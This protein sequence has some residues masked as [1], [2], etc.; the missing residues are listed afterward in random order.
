MHPLGFLTHRARLGVL[1]AKNLNDSP[2]KEDIKGVVVIVDISGYTKLTDSLARMGSSERLREI[3]NPPFELIIQTIHAHN[4]SIIKFAGDSVLAIWNPAVEKLNMKDEEREEGKRH[5]RHEEV[6][7]EI[8]GKVVQCCCNLMCLF[9]EYKLQI[10]DRWAGPN[11]Q[12]RVSTVAPPEADYSTVSS[13]KGGG[14]KQTKADRRNSGFVDSFLI[15]MNDSGVGRKNSVRRNQHDATSPG[16]NPLGIDS[17]RIHIGVGIGHFRHVFLGKS[18]PKAQSPI[19]QLEGEEGEGDGQVKP[20]AAPEED[21]LR[22]EQFVSGPAVQE[23][24]DMLVYGKTGELALP[25]RILSHFRR[26]IGREPRLNLLIQGG[27]E[28]PILPNCCIVRDKFEDIVEILSNL[29]REFWSSSITSD[30][31]SAWLTREGILPSL[32]KNM[33]A[34]MKSLIFM[35][36]SLQQFF[37]SKLKE[38]QKQIQEQKELLTGGDLMSNNGSLSRKP[39]KRRSERR[40]SVTEDAR[41][42]ALALINLD[43]YNQVRR[44][45]I[46]F[47]Q[48]QGLSLDT[49]GAD[50]NLPDLQNFMDA[51]LVGVNTHGGCCRQLNCDEKGLCALLVWGLEGFAHEKGEEKHAV[52]AAL[53][54][55]QSLLAIFGSS[56]SIGVTAGQVFAGVIGDENR[57]DGT[58]LGPCVNLAA[59][60]MC[61]PIC[62][63]RVLCDSEIYRACKNDF[64]FDSDFQALHLKGVQDAVLVYEPHEK[65]ETDEQSTAGRNGL[66]NVDVSDRMIAGRHK[67]KEIISDVIGRWLRNERSTLLITGKS[68]SGKTFLVKNIQDSLKNDETIIVCNAAGHENRQSAFFIFEYIIEDI[69]S[70]LGHYGWTPGKIRRSRRAL[71]LGPR[72]ST[73]SAFF[74]GSSM[75]ASQYRVDARRRTMKSMASQSGMKESNYLLSKIESSDVLAKQ[76]TASI[77]GEDPL[78]ELL[79]ALGEPLST[80]ELLRNMFPRLFGRFTHI[81]TAPVQDVGPRLLSYI[82]RILQTLS[83]LGFRIAFV[84]DDVQEYKENLRT[85]FNLVCD[86]KYCIRVPVEKL[87]RDAVAEM[88]KNKFVGQNIESIAPSLLTEVF[89]KTQGNPLVV[90]IFCTM[91]FNDENIHVDNGVLCRK[92][93][94]KDLN[95]QSLPS[96]TGSAVIAQFDKLSSNMKAI[97]RVASVAGQYFHVEEV[98]YVLQASESILSDTI[99]MEEMRQL[100]Q[101]SDPFDLIQWN[102]HENRFLFSHYLIQQGIYTSLVPSRREELHLHF[103]DYY[104]SSMT[105]EN[106]KD[107]V[108]SIISHLMKIP[109]DEERKKKY[110]YEAFAI[111]VSNRRSLEGLEYYNLYKGFCETTPNTE[112]RELVEEGREERLLMQLYYEMKDLKTAMSHFRQALRLYGLEFPNPETDMLALTILALKF[113]FFVKGLIKLTEEQKL[114]RCFRK[115]EKLFKNIFKCFDKKMVRQAMTDIKKASSRALPK[116]SNRISLERT[117]EVELSRFQAFIEEMIDLLE[118]GLYVAYHGKASS[119]APSIASMLLIMHTVN[120][121]DRSALGTQYGRAGNTMDVLG[122]ANSC[123]R[124]HEAAI[125]YL[126]D[127]QET[128]AEIMEMSRYSETRA[129]VYD[130]RGEWEACI[131]FYRVH[132]TSLESIGDGASPIAFLNRVVDAVVRELFADYSPLRTYLEEKYMELYSGQDDCWDI[133]IVKILL[134]NVRA[135]M[136]DIDKAEGF[137]FVSLRNARDLQLIHAGPLYLKE[138]PLLIEVLLNIFEFCGA[139]AFEA[140]K[141]LAALKSKVKPKVFPEEV[142]KLNTIAQIIFHVDTAAATLIADT[143]RFFPKRPQYSEYFTA[144]CKVLQ[145]LTKGSLESFAEQL[146]ALMFKYQ[147]FSFVSTASNHVMQMLARA[148]RARKI[149]TQSPDFLMMALQNRTKEAPAKTKKKT[150]T[151]PEEYESPEKLAELL[152]EHCMNWE[153][154]M[155]R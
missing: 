71:D 45:C 15:K 79:L 108:P 63:S 102:N 90:K 20:I 68:G 134:A 85:R 111:S 147:K 56:F 81:S 12:G 44:V 154:Y 61:Q 58:V 31:D 65:S 57:C 40:S 98:H 30:I 3:L 52:A 64:K 72:V 2:C 25:F 48:V 73:E 128:Y 7:E 114:S 82:S 91:L 49:I 131:A 149:N 74:D 55:Q 103:A 28:K 78:S 8:L 136:G 93:G 76:R 95:G 153:A 141:Q 4:G 1:G 99:S 39:T 94:M 69:S 115:S 121:S 46:V 143:K 54:I 27:D 5:R 66:K 86:S 36:E 113:A 34:C 139:E 47:I 23:A 13:E 60:I 107:N 96:D 35:D 70:H 9:K 132:L 22:I 130:S 148:M 117:K 51:V 146:R 17:L 133:S 106:R 116:N 75:N 118:T 67:E 43:D 29:G 77:T 123:N 119:D 42:S 87:D 104:E 21:R 41:D 19:I 140:V 124:M 24:G 88:I 37:N 62:T 155:L 92:A 89:E 151:Y 59:R 138:L 38:V 150:V 16:T 127:H 50:S 100:L 120:M 110:L 80:I 135:T 32:A 126:P 122:M 112:K 26:Y 97:L 10:P 144:A 145:V 125:P 105:D 33:E 14:G 6:L 84:L 11:I 109:G 152:K 53:Q 129:I 142:K 101:T 18:K 137:Y 83:K